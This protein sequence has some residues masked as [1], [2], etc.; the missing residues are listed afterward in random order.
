MTPLAL[1]IIA[2][3]VACVIAFGAGWR[4]KG[5]ADQVALDAE[6]AATVQAASDFHAREAGLAANLAAA[7]AKS[8]ATRQVIEHEIVKLVDRP[9]YRDSVCLDP[10]G[11]RLI[12]AARTGQA[13]ASGAS[14]VL[15][16]ATAASGPVGG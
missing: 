16:A 8:T 5:N 3:L 6:H 11:L 9:V 12:E 1:E 10:D 7:L 15:P 13:A 14:A 2:A 4:I